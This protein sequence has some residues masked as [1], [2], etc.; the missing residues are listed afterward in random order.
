MK[1]RMGYFLI[2]LEL[3]LL[4]FIGKS[5]SFVAGHRKNSEPLFSGLPSELLR[6]SPKTSEKSFYFF[7]AHNTSVFVCPPFFLFNTMSSNDDDASCSLS[8]SLLH[9]HAHAHAHSLSLSL[10]L[11][12]SVNFAFCCKVWMTISTY[13]SLS[14]TF[15]QDISFSLLLALRHAHTC[16][17]THSLC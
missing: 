7:S 5:D 4:L 15:Q 13:L 2:W 14:L 9:A 17:H 6:L 3:G 1:W 11:P 12:L 8:L 16:A 10:S